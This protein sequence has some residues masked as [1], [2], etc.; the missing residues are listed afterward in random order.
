[1]SLAK[2]TSL[3][4][5]SLSLLLERQRLQSLP[6]FSPSP[7]PT[8]GTPAPTSNPHH[9]PQITRN[10][11]QLHAGILE[12]EREEAGNEAVVLLA[13]QYE[14]MRGMLGEVDGAGVESLRRSKP[15]PT[16]AAPSS[17]A[18][19]FSFSPPTPPMKN[20]EPAYARYTDDPEMGYEPGIMLQAQ[21]RMMNEQDDE[22][23]RLSHS[24][25]RQ[26]DIS[27]QINDE[28]DVHTGLLEELDTDLDHTES[29]LGG[30]RRRLDK[31]AKGAKE[32]GSTVTIALLILVL[33][34]LIVVFKT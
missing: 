32:N 12:L 7:S 14:R 17:S 26:R 8:L 18:P 6:S 25:N 31:F 20:P 27:L 2:L 3:S 30:A 23:D 34:V 16:G 10:L 15:Q 13:N 24:I 33:L 1:M 4:T 21:R 29:R 5:Q 28:L 11:R 22:L 9:V 19:A